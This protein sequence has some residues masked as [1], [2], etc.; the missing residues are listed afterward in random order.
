[1]E[2][3]KH[4]DRK[5]CIIALCISAFAATGWILSIE[6]GFS[7]D[8]YTTIVR[9]WGNAETFSLLPRWRYNDRPVGVQ[10]VALLYTI[11]G[12]NAQGYH[13]V[14]F[15]IHLIN[16]YLVYQAAKTLLE[17]FGASETELS[18]IFAAALFGA[19]PQ[20]VMAPQWI[21]AVF[22]MLCSL[23]FLF[24]MYFFLKK[25]K[26]ENYAAFYGILVL[27]NYILSIRSKEMSLLLPLVF[28]MF[29]LVQRK[30]RGWKKRIS[31]TTWC[32][33]FWM[34]VVC[35]KLFSFPAIENGAYKQG[36][37]LI[38]IF[39]NFWRYIGLYADVFT[40][41]MM[42]SP[43]SPLIAKL[44]GTVLIVALI[45]YA[46]W[47][48][49]NRKWLPLLSLLSGGLLLT[50]VLTMGEMQHKLYLYIPSIF[51]AIAFSAVL[52]AGST[53]CKKNFS[54]IVLTAIL[55]IALLNYLPGPQ[56]FRASWCSTTKQDARQLGQIYRL[57]DLPPYCNIYV[58]G[59]T[60]EY[61]VIYPYGPGNSVKVLY[62][63]DDIRCEA[64]DEFPAEPIRPYVFWDYKDGCFTETAR[65][66]DSQIEVK[67]VS[68]ARMNE[69]IVAIGVECQP[70]V[71][72]MKIYIDGKEYNT[73]IGETF[74]STEYPFK[75]GS[76]AQT[77]KI[78]V[79]SEA[80]GNV[81]TEEKPLTVQK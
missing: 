40:A 49:K 65:D 46:F 47:S 53:F 16:T 75:A 5:A 3:K 18:P 44:P 10:F 42:Y 41:P 37:S 33:L 27:I 68:C 61:N 78:F 45:L 39:R 71:P 8:D 74:L 14:F 31:R 13:F 32:C 73:T 80:L 9:G 54:G 58:R 50:P 26:N 69:D 36:Y 43:Y 70:I 79:S 81:R 17:D 28:V 51:L 63:R 30:D 48:A 19:Y 62:G 56:N 67:N 29:D 72:D 1:M 59:A 66:N 34:A 35:A 4:L 12:R 6:N 24:A 22:D 76:A 2:K 25:D 38:Q 20:S 77:I 57:G 55:M 52:S 64:V 23:F 60:E 15:V 11:F 7:L 21:S